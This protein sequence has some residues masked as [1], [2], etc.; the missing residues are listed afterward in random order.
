SS[1]RFCVDSARTEGSCRRIPSHTSNT[2]PDESIRYQETVK[3]SM[4]LSTSLSMMG[5]TPQRV[6]VV[7]ANRNP[8]SQRPDATCMCVLGEGIW[9]A[10]YCRARRDGMDRQQSGFDSRSKLVAMNM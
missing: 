4:P 3:A 2:R 8:Y 7:N 6:V 1:Q 10:A 9:E 5:S